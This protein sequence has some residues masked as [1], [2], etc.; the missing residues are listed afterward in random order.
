MSH[1]RLEF[2]HTIKLY[3]KNLKVVGLILRTHVFPYQLLS[4]HHLS[5]LSNKP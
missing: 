5:H 2:H 3:G 1:L 4:Y